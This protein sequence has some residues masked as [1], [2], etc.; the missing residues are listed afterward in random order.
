MRSLRTQV[1]GIDVIMLRVSFTGDLGF[2][3]YTQEANQVA[4]YQAVLQ[5]G[6]EY[7]I[8]PVGGRAL[9]SMRVEKGYGSWGREYSPEY[10]P[11]EVGLD[12]LI[13]LDKPT[14]L[15]RDAYLKLK[16]QTPRWRLVTLAVEAT[17]ADASGGEPICLGD[18]TPVGQV[19]SGTYGFTVEKSLAMGF[20]R[21]EHIDPTQAYQVM[22]LG[23]PHAATLLS[24]AAFDPAGQRLRS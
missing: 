1:A 16:D 8:R 19:S 15:G 3:I 23:Q 2:E 11:Q 24:E 9:L 14:F 13:K 5:A 12:R 4:L 17:T 18:G 21:N 6:A 22:I 7:E 20:I 10:W